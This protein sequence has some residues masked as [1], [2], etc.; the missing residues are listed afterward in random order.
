MKKG[1]W[2]VKVEK[3][4]NEGELK[5]LI[6][7]AQLEFENPAMQKTLLEKVGSNSGGEFVA[8]D[9]LSKLPEKIS[10]KVTKVRQQNEQKLWDNWLFLLLITLIAG[11][12]WAIRKKTDLP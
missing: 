9:Q 8:L 1:E 10:Q 3:Y 4:E 2:S 7:K 5:L 11:L 12:E 6:R